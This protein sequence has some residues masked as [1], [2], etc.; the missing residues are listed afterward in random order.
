MTQSVVI[1]SDSTCDLSQELL[2]RYDIPVIPL[3]ITLG[4]DT[5]FGRQQLYPA[6][7]VCPL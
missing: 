1:T 7:Y 6:G 5:F 3:T 2:D 4:E